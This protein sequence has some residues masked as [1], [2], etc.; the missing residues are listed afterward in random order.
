MGFFLK[1]KKEELVFVFDIRSSSVGA[2]VFLLSKDGISKIIYSTREKIKLEDNLDFKRFFYLTCKALDI[3]VNKVCVKNFGKPKKII[4]VLSSP[5]YSSETRTISLKKNITFVFTNKLADSL[6]Q[7]EISLF[8]EEYLEKYKHLDDKIKLLEFRNMKILLNGYPSSEPLNQ[9]IKDLEMIIYVSMAEEKILDKFKSIIN[10]HFNFRDIKFTSFLMNSFAVARDIFVH[11]DSFL[12]VDIGGE[13][14]DIS[15]VKKDILRSSVSFPLGKNFL[16]KGI[17]DGLACSFEEAQSYLSLYKDNHDLE[18]FR[19]KVEPVLNKL[20]I[21]WMQRF[22]ESL[23][24]VSNDI[25]IPSVIFVT[26]DQ[27]LAEFFI[28]IIKKEQFNQYSL[29][30]SKFKVIFL[31]NQTLHGIITLENEFTKDSLLVLES[32]YISRFLR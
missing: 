11:E 25:S 5:W 22:Q 21:N 26:A 10:K 2:A 31:N 15:M 7:K 18:S 24:G 32:I 3:V 30:D 1:S 14:T 20:R 23:A 29:T 4:C 13:I 9:K 28:D 6:I 19:D 12:L 8:E 17:K 27:D 16:I